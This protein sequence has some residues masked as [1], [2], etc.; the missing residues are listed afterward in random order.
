MSPLTLVHSKW[1]SGALV[2]HDAGDFGVGAEILRIAQ[3]DIAIGTSTNNVTM[4]MYGDVTLSGD[5]TLST[6]DISVAQGKYVYLDGQSGGEYIRSDTADYLM[7]N[8]TTGVDLAI[9]GTDEVNITATAV[10]LPTNN[11]TLTAGEISVAATH[12][13]YLDGQGGSEYVRAVTDG[14]AILNGATTAALGIAGTAV[15]TV[16]AATATFAQKIVQDDTTAS[17]DTVTG[18]IQTDGGLGVAGRGNFGSNVIV[19]TGVTTTATN[20]L[21]SVLTS[22]GAAGY[23]GS[24]AGVRGRVY[25][26]NTAGSLGNAYGGWFGYT[27]SSG[28]VVSGGLTCGVYAEADSETA[29]VPSAVAYFQV[30][31]GATANY[32]NMPILVLTDDSTNKSNYA[33]SLGFA[34]AATTV[35]SG[36]SGDIL[37]QQTIHIMANGSDAYIPYSTTEGTYTTAYLIAGTG[38]MTMTTAAPAT[39]TNGIY[40]LMTS[41][42]SW[43]GSVTPFRSRN[44]VTATGAGGNCYGGWFNL[45]FSSGAPTGL[46]LSA[47]L[48]VEAG[49]NIATTGVSS[50]LMATL[51]G[52]ADGAITNSPILTL[53]DASTLKTNILLEVGF[54]AGATTVGT[55]SS[56][57]TKLYRTSVTAATINGNCTEALRVMVNGSIRWIP[58]ATSPD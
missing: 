6:E 29:A 23:T 51:L 11:L 13:V 57:T 55:A 53:A 14:N 46:G 22:T 16:A 47:G 17:T 31:G 36:S 56:G 54:N 9:G 43:T 19:T 10:T 40:S 45:L 30:A 44:T 7:L 34:P 12:Y 50:V 32:A 49:S 27:H 42:A 38:T 24:M 15:I 4:T 39:A 33:F 18:S 2:F 1:D 35:S 3:D 25:I 58:L 37:Y 8:G 21:Y 20:G 48:Y 28:A 5:L 41:S 26:Q 52:D